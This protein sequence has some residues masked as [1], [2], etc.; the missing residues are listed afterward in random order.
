MTNPTNQFDQLL[1]TLDPDL[2]SPQIFFDSE[3]KL[4]SFCGRENNQHFSDLET[5]KKY[6]KSIENNPNKS[7]LEKENR[8]SIYLPDI[9]NLETFNDKLLLFQLRDYMHANIIKNTQNLQSNN[10]F[11]LYSRLTFQELESLDMINSLKNGVIYL[12]F[13]LW[14]IDAVKS[15]IDVDIYQ[16][17]IDILE[18]NL[19]STKT[20]SPILEFS[21]SDIIK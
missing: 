19:F 9:I 8:L 21:K 4:T 15:S 18:R 20:N 3:L 14:S 7:E 16:D 17:E 11:Y 5:V 12:D 2:L 13:F 10:Q 6:F 1:K